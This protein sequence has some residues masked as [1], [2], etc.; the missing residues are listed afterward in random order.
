M[1]G[2]KQK[3]KVVL[4]NSHFIQL[5]LGLSKDYWVT[6]GSYKELNQFFMVQVLESQGYYI[7]NTAQDSALAIKSKYI[8]MLVKG[9]QGKPIILC[10]DLINK[11]YAA[12]SCINQ[13]LSVSLLTFLL[14]I[15]VNSYT[16]ILRV[17]AYNI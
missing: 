4:I 16:I 1:G 5:Y 3:L 14:K 11:F 2:G 7:S 17:R 12:S 6:E 9:C 8:N 10:E 13:D 15:A